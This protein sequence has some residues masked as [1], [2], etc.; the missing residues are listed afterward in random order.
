[1]AFH[2]KRGPPGNLLR[3]HKLRARRPAGWT[4]MCQLG[5][6]IQLKGVS[7]LHGLHGGDFLVGLG[8]A[9]GLKGALSKFHTYNS[10]HCRAHS[11]LKNLLNYQGFLNYGDLRTRS[12]CPPCCG[13]CLGG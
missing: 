10:R 9:K 8:Q 11:P 5:V 1:M 2:R 7:A 6:A 4:V 13:I 12:H 3:M